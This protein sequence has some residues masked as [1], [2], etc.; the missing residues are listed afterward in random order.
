M[1][2]LLFSSTKKG[3]LLEGG[4]LFEGGGGG[5]GLIDDLRY[6][7]LSSCQ[8][9]IPSSPNCS[10]PCAQSSR[11]FLALACLFFAGNFYDYDDI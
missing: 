2:G 9:D 3:G 4:V 1:G 5:G 6:L 7:V 8:H 10:L 11:L